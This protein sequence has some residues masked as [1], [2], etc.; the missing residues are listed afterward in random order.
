[1]AKNTNVYKIIINLKVFCINIY[2]YSYSFLKFDYYIN[3]L[4]KN[5][6]KNLLTLIKIN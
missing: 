4:A 2:M 1:M 5:S 3:V 6:F